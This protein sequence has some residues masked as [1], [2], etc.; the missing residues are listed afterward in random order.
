MYVYSKGLNILDLQQQGM[1][2]M[3]LKRGRARQVTKK[4]DGELV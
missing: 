1:L 4:R 3:V 2:N